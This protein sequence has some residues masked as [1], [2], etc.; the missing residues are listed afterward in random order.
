MR[1]YIRFVIPLFFAVMGIKYILP[2]SSDGPVYLVA[3]KE[4]TPCKTD[5][6]NEIHS[7][8]VLKSFWL[9]FEFV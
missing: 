3:L 1:K 9:E 8:S 2:F 5:E 4:N 7:I 6:P